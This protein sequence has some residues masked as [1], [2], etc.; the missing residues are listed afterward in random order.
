MS[1]Q[2]NDV[3]GDFQYKLTLDQ[4]TP[5]NA[6]ADRHLFVIFAPQPGDSALFILFFITLGR[7]RYHTG[8]QTLSNLFANAHSIAQTDVNSR[9]CIPRK[10]MTPPADVRLGISEGYSDALWSCRYIYAKT[11]IFQVSILNVLI[12]DNGHSHTQK[13]INDFFV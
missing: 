7:K 13:K 3:R 1:G 12:T 2:Y 4:G 11:D 10:I 6:D 8:S 5:A 9:S